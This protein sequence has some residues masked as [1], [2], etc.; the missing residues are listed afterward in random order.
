VIER[1]LGSLTDIVDELIVIHDGPCSDRT[2]QI[3]EA[4]GA[5]VV[6]AE[7]LG[8]PEAHTVS[9]YKLARGQWLLNID[10]DEFLSPQMKAA[11]PGLVGNDLVNGYEFFWPLW[12]GARYISSSGPYK[13]ALSRRSATHLLGMLQSVERVDAPVERLT[14]QLEHRPQY[15]NFTLGSMRSK[16]DRWARIHA[17]ELLGPYD[18]IAK[19]NWDGI[20]AWPWYH[21]LALS[22]SPLLVV[23]MPPLM[24]FKFMWASRNQMSL[25]DNARTSILLC[26]YIGLLHYHVAAGRYRSHGR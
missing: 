8:N 26:A 25:R 2:L 21:R 20:H 19:F 6:V 5:V 16:W 3:A 17:G 22:I 12:N 7:D 15:N 10:A 1:C 18:A 13:L 4:H 14:L 23:A 24:F 9:A 11:I